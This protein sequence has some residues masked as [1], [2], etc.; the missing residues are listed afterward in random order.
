MLH[1]RLAAVSDA[2]VTNVYGAAREFCGFA[3]MEGL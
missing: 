3:A 1:L 2:C